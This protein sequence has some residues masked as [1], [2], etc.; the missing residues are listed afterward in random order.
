MY[1]GN[2]SLFQECHPWVRM[3][4]STKR[5]NEMESVLRKVDLGL[6]AMSECII[7]ITATLPKQVK[8][9]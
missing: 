3:Y 6:I 4:L 1:V 5:K 8:F 2:L 7:P 9:S